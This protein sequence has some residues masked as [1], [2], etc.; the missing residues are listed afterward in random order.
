MIDAALCGYEY[1]GLAK[2]LN[3]PE[4]R[5]F[6]QPRRPIS[7]VR[8]TRFRCFTTAATMSACWR[9]TTPR[10]PRSP[11]PRAY[12]FSVVG[13]TNSWMSG[14]SAYYCE[15]IANADLVGIHTASSSRSVAP[16]SAGPARCSAP[17]R[18][19]LGCRRPRA[20]RARHGHLG[21]YGN[22]AG[23]ARA[24]R[25]AAAR[26]RG[27]RFARAARPA[28]RPRRG[29]APCCRLAATRA[30]GSGLSS[31]RSACSPAR[32][33]TPTVTTA[34]CSSCS[35][36]ICWCRSTTFKRE[37][38]AL[39]DRIKSVPRAPG[40]EEIR[41]PGERAFQ[42]RE[43]LLR[44]GI[45]I[46]RLGLRGARS[47]AP[48]TRQSARSPRR[49]GALRRRV[50]N[51]R[52]GRRTLGIRQRPPASGESATTGREYFS[53]TARRYYCGARP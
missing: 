17:I 50:G 23:V 35:S 38:A 27:D 5:R 3:I 1:S 22:R 2:I 36:P 42:S 8:E 34:T 28:T 48:L 40:V 15:M 10:A 24:A 39:I 7:V 30:T 25:T 46:D 4:H 44:E 19:P 21:F 29:T 53:Q 45:E 37:V 11:R 43:R 31:R 32:R 14:R 33:W 9:C 12:G 6:K 41:I 51:P 26:R 18:S 13:V 20:D 47:A 52:S 49:G 16:V